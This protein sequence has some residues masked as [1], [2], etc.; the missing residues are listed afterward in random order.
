[1]GIQNLQLLTRYG[2][3]VDE[4]AKHLAIIAKGDRPEIFT[5]H[6]LD[7]LNPASLFADPPRTALDV[8]SGAGFPGIPLAIVWP[9]TR[10]FLVESRE[11]KA[12]FIEKAA[13]D[14]GLKN[15]EVICA[16]VEDLA[17]GG[18]HELGST[19]ESAFVRAVGNLPHTLAAVAGVSAPGARWIYFLGGSGDARG[20]TATL[21]Q[22]GKGARAEAGSFGGSLL[23][24][25]IAPTAPPTL[26]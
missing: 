7:S 16:R 13:R 23:H 22:H 4:F 26:S 21:G 25:V 15:V 20:L 2:L 11:K 24:G 3:L 5:R 8:G 6:V 10:W 19:V 1:M 17:P 14:L 9:T 18:A 12:G